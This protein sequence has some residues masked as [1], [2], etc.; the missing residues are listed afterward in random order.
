MIYAPKYAGLSVSFQMQ[1]QVGMLG[2][3]EFIRKS[4]LKLKPFHGKLQ[5]NIKSEIFIIPLNIL[6]IFRSRSQRNKSA[7]LQRSLCWHMIII[8]IYYRKGKDS[9]IVY[10]D[11]PNHLHAKF[12]N[13][14]KKPLLQGPKRCLF[15]SHS[16][17]FPSKD[18]SAKAL[19]LAC[20]HPQGKLSYRK[21]NLPHPPEKSIVLIF[22]GG[23]ASFELRPIECCCGTSNCISKLKSEAYEVLK[24]T[25]QKRHLSMRRMP[26]PH[27]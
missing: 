13:H 22:V 7:P 5:L 21:M 10:L 25:K 3:R 6:N 18:N 12:L 23:G 15:L 26:I 9:C 2:E 1:P 16:V 27:T 4:L 11:G 14:I 17:N 24:Q 20:T 19:W 8:I